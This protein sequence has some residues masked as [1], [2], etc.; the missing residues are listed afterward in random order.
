MERQQ[1]TRKG[2]LH[3]W[4]HET[5]GLFTPCKFVFR[6]HTESSIREKVL[7]FAQQVWKIEINSGKMVKGLEVFLFKATTGAL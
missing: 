1:E 5:Q 2:C 7:K 4:C 6:V 3:M